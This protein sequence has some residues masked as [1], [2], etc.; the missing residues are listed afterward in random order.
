MFFWFCWFCLFVLGTVYTASKVIA[1]VESSKMTVLP[2]F[3]L[4]YRLGTQKFASSRKAVRADLVFG[5]V[6]TNS[7]GEFALRCFARSGFK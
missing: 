6:C 3:C 5:I 4:S 7:Y 1:D 2:F